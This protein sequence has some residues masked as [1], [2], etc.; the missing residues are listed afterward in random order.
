MKGSE[1]YV[2]PL[3]F[4]EPNRIAPR[5]LG[6]ELSRELAGIKSIFAT[7]ARYACLACRGL[8]QVAHHAQRRER[9]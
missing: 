4:I 1:T 2:F 3:P 7:Q 9:T 8:L 5:A 6:G